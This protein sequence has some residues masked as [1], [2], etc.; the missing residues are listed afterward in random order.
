MTTSTFGAGIHPDLPDTLVHLTGRP[1][2]RADD[3]PAGFAQG[4]PDDR[5]AG[6][7]HAGAIAATRVWRARGPVV[8][9]SEASSAALATLFS[10]GVTYRGPYSPWAVMLDRAAAVAAGAR[11]VWHMGDDALAATESLP[12]Y[13][14]DLRVR[15]VPGAADWLAERE[16]RLCWGDTPIAAGNIPGF[17]LAGHA[18]GVIVGVRGWLPL[19]RPLTH[20]PQTGQLAF[21]WPV[22][23]LSRWWWNGQT[24]VNDG[25]LDIQNQAA[26]YGVTAPIA[27]S[28]NGEPNRIPGGEY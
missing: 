26:V 12:D 27:P 25:S 23:G 10:T 13:L 17:T 7:A 5:L 4:G 21:A 16:W 3:Q 18:T 2:V 15:Y 9:L 20:G 19:P 1:R 11:P 8:C 22:H 28:G 24:M 6:I 14:A